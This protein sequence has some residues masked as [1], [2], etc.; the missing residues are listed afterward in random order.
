[1][2]MKFKYLVK[3]TDRHGNDRY[4][5]R[6]P[7]QR[8]IR[9][10]SEFGT[11]E[12]HE[13]YL[14]AVD[15]R[16]EAV[17]VSDTRVKRPA[18]GTMHWLCKEYFEAALFKE[19]DPRTQRV[20]RG[21]LERFCQHKNG[22][23]NPYADL[24]PRHIRKVRDSMSDR[25]EAANGMI[26]SLR[27]VFKFAIEYDLHDRNPAKDVDYLKSNPDG[28]PAWSLEE[29][30]RFEA[31]HPVGSKARLLLSLA[32]YTG[33][34]RADLVTLGKQHVK[35]GW[36]HFRQHKGRN[37]KPVDLAI[38]IVP[39]LQEAIEKTETGD[40]TFLVSERGQPYTANSIGNRFKKWCREAGIHNRSLHGLRKAAAAR[41]AERGCTEQEIMAITGHRT[42]KEVTRYTRSASQKKRAESALT[43][44]SDFSTE[45][46]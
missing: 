23:Q 46:R 15:S 17:P 16:Q 32:L 26:K 13:D 11:K 6:K 2:K 10:M 45:E 22:G 28:F 24:L 38:P 37:H 5:Y 18:H 14:R 36:L 19:L 1:M 30:E 12:F 21:I 31:T 34:R 42:S 40:L 25:P 33:Q 20:R 39:E 27:Q 44:L 4:Y 3:D 8:K 7:G 41:L 35:D 43:R 9:L 29:V